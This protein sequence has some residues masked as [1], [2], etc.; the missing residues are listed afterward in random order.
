MAFWA[1]NSSSVSTP[2]A[3]ARR[4]T[5]RV[6]HCAASRPASF[7]TLHLHRGPQSGPGPESLGTLTTEPETDTS[8]TGTQG[9]NDGRPARLLAISCAT[10]RARA[11]GCGRPSSKKRRWF[12]RGRNSGNCSRPVY[13]GPVQQVALPPP[14]LHA[15]GERTVLTVTLSNCAVAG[16][17]SPP[18]ARP[19]AVNPNP[20]IRTSST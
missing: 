6:R 1:A 18:T 16:G 19:T 3:L 10:R 9:T 17:E 2:A 5:G 8:R 15:T 4:R 7:N 13:C 14:T 12:L 20:G 11:A